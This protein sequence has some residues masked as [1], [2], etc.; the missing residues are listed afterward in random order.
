MTDYNFNPKIGDKI[1]DL[2][3]DDDYKEF[4]KNV[5]ELEKLDTLESDI[6]FNTEYDKR[7]D[8]FL[9]KHGNDDST[10]DD[11]DDSTDDDSD[12]N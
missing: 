8:D 1:D 12:D 9:K 4:L 2:P 3:E 5:L 6:K 7:T 11:S 10:D